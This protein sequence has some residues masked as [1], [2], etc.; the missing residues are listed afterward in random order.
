MQNKPV[1]I[2][3]SCL[4]Q[5]ESF[6]KLDESLVLMEKAALAAI[7]DTTNTEIKNFID[8][9]RIPKGY[10]RY[11]DPGK[12]IATK[13]NFKKDI[14]TYITKIGVLQ[15]NLI[16]A[17]NTAKEKN[18]TLIGLLGRNGGKLLGLVDQNITIKINKT[19]RIQEMHSLIIHIICYI[20]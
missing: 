7:S 3:V 2:G 5:K 16:N 18:T 11:R 15:Q 10:W 20:F 8:E 6:D 12:W 1:V 4:Q 19:S 9:I 17:A 13:N 14:K